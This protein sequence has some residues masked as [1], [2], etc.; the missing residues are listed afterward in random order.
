MTSLP[1]LILVQAICQQQNWRMSFVRMGGI[2]FTSRQK[3]LAW[4]AVPWAKFLVILLLLPV[5]MV[6]RLCLLPF[7]LARHTDRVVQRLKFKSSSEK[8]R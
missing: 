2:P 4:Q 3:L 7:Q 8:K 1:S 6:L 5:I